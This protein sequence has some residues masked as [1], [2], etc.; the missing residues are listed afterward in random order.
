MT[1]RVFNFNVLPCGESVTVEIDEISLDEANNRRSLGT[2]YGIDFNHCVCLGRKYV[3]NFAQRVRAYR[4]IE[5]DKQLEE[6]REFQPQTIGVEFY[7][8]VCL[9]HE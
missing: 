8:G 5:D 1:R 6:M 2:T 3:E 4:I 7:E 9:D